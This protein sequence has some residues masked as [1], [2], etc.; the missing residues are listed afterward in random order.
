[1]AS[2][3]QLWLCKAAQI[4]QHTHTHVQLADK[5]ALIVR[6]EDDLLASRTGHGSAGS[7]SGAG[8]GGGG[9]SSSR[10]VGVLSFVCKSS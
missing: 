8:G 9:G 3:L 5:Q 7:S 1:M 6:L 10:Q 2:W 4:R